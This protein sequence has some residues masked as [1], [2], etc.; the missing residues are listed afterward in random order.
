[1]NNLYIYY[2]CIFNN[3]NASAFFSVVLPFG[4]RGGSH[5]ACSEC[6]PSAET[7]GGGWFCGGAEAVRNDRGGVEVHP[8][9]EQA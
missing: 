2:V 1:M 4:W 9:E 5:E 3:K 6:G 7:V 8:P